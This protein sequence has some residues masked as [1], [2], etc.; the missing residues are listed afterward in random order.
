MAWVALVLWG[1]TASPA[2]DAAGEASQ[3]R[4]FIGER[5]VCV[6]NRF[7]DMSD[8]PELVEGQIYTIKEILPAKRGH[9]GIEVVEV[10]AKDRY[11]AFDDRR[12]ER[13]APFTTAARQA[14]RGDGPS[15]P[16]F[17]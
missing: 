2:T 10:R 13:L 11:L 16:T 15:W 5:I 9:L 17:R 7:L 3:S 14:R 8:A 6:T 4:W 1:V 12:F